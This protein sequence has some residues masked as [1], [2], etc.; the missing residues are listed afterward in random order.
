MK[1]PDAATL[2]RLIVDAMQADDWATVTDLEPRLDAVTQPKNPPP[3][4]SAAL[5]YAEQGLRI[6]PL[7]PRSKLPQKGSKGFKDA[8]TDKWKI[9]GWWQKSPDSN[10]AI[11]TGYLVDVIDFDGI[12][13]VKS[14]SENLNMFNELTHLGHVST[15]RPG[16][17]HIYIPASP[18]RTN[19]AQLLPGVDVRAAGGYVCAPPSKTDIGTYTWRIPLNLEH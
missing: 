10:V 13:G 3:L 15:P 7:Q 19:K 5:W 1:A 17:T 4:V 16:G 14:W 6:F 9:I 18:I 8:T 12:V 11:A 2:E